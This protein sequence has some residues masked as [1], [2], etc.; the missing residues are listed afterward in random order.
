MQK[1]QMWR[2]SSLSA[3]GATSKFMVAL[4]KKLKMQPQQDETSNLPSGYLSHSR[5]EH[6][7]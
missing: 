6:P 7:F 3:M 4:M 1:A 2:V 5:L